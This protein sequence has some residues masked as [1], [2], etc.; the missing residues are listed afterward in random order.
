MQCGNWAI[1][2]GAPYTMIIF[3]P[4]TC[5][6]ATL[7]GCWTGHLLC[8][9]LSFLNVIF[10]TTLNLQAP[11]VNSR[12]PIKQKSHIIC[13]T[14]I[15]R[16]PF[17]QPHPLPA[18]CHIL[19]SITAAKWVPHHK[20][21]H[22]IVHQTR[23]FHYSVLANGPGWQAILCACPWSS[24]GTLAGISGPSCAGRQTTTKYTRR[25][26]LIISTEFTRIH[27]RIPDWDKW[28]SSYLRHDKYYW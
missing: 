12:T 22:N 19:P 17:I 7:P 28:I 2:N 13:K 11:S 4:Y 27:F 6:R 25:K 18:P 21:R 23:N 9:T 8:V 5:S 3:L 14:T 26:S 1:E 15:H 24:L 10:H 20:T 16:R